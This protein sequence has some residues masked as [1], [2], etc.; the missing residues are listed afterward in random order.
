[1]TVKPLLEQIIPIYN[2]TIQ[3]NSLTS[4]L[5]VEGDNNS[6]I[7]WFKLYKKFNRVDL[8]TYACWILIERSDG[9]SYNIPVETELIDD[10]IYIKWTVTRTDCAIP[11]LTL[12]SIKI[13]N[14]DTDYLWQTAPARFRVVDQIDCSGMVDPVEPN[15]LDAAILKVTELKNETQGLRDQTQS[16]YDSTKQL[17]DEFAETVETAKQEIDQ[18]AEEVMSSFD[19][20]AQESIDSILPDMWA[21]YA[22]TAKV[23]QEKT[24]ALI[25]MSDKKNGPTSARVYS[26]GAN[27]WE[28]M[29]YFQNYGDFSTLDDS[30]FKVVAYDGHSDPS[31]ATVYKHTI[32]E[33]AYLALKAN[34]TKVTLYP[35]F[36]IGQLYIPNF[37]WKFKA[38][39]ELNAEA[40]G[41][42]AS[43]ISFTFGDIDR[44]QYIVNLDCTNPYL[45]RIDDAEPQ[46]TQNIDI[47]LQSDTI[48]DIYIKATADTVYC[49]IANGGESKNATI[50]R[51][52]PYQGNLT[53][54]AQNTTVYLT[55]M[56][57][58]QLQE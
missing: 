48:Y 4:L 56:I 16:I 52:K 17:T 23:T 54:A 45:A 14:S 43:A 6:S 49:S 1:M 26:G 21:D 47:T 57:I 15:I 12:V 36:N 55:D 13:G 32:D 33:T 5:S 53:L 7:K 39:F 19:E 37:V 28:E 40:V 2:R 3:I 24:G 27:L 41:P 46:D 30:T 8:S 35:N 10:Y 11:G 9:S 31:G 42:A 20:R 38:R 44:N 25:E 58:Q 22:P 50:S 29:P 51:T 18:K 34:G